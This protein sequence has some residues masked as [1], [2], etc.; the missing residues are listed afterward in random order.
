MR[1][2]KIKL[3]NY[4]QY[5]D[6]ELS[7]EQTSGNDLHIIV[8]KNGTGKTN[9][10]NAINWCL[11][12]EEP[13]LSKDSE[14]LP[15]LNT[16]TIAESDGGKQQVAVELW[17]QAD[18]RQRI[19]FVRKEYYYIQKDSPPTFS[20][21]DFYV[22]ITDDRGSTDISEDDD[23][24]VVA[25]RFVPKKIRD[26]FFFDGERL[27]NYFRYSTRE[28]IKSAIFGISQIDLLT[29]T[30]D[31]LSKVL[32]ELQKEAGRLS[33]E[34]DRIRQELEDK[35]ENL[36]EILKRIE[37]C[38]R[39]IE[40]AREK[41]AENR[42]KVKG[43]P[44]IETL[45]GIREKLRKKVKEI[46]EARENKQKE[47]ESLLFEFGKILMLY[48]TITKSLEI[49]QEK[50]KSGEILPTIDKDLIKRILEREEPCIC[51]RTVDDDAEKNLK[52]L[53]SK[54][55]VSSEV[56]RELSTMCIYLNEAKEKAKDFETSLKSIRRD[57]RQYDERLKELTDQISSIDKQIGGYD[58][59]KIKDW[60]KE[61]KK[62]EEIYEGNQQNL[63]VLKDQKEKIESRIISL[64][65]ERDK[66][67]G[68]VEKLEEQK[69]SID[70][71]QKALRVL[72]RSQKYVID[73]FKQ[74]MEEETKSLFF[75][76]I[77]K[78][79]TYKDII[80][81]EGYNIHLI[82]SIGY[83]SLGS[84]SASERELLALAFTIAL[85]KISGFA[86][87]IL[88]DTPATRLSSEHKEKFADIFSNLSEEKQIILL[89][90]PDEY[91]EEMRAILD[92]KVS[93][94]YELKLTPDEKEVRI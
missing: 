54:I 64:K 33:P 17:M 34:I 39:Q 89:V 71:T 13:H 11:Y 36:K 12:N 29:R 19:I 7:F 32:M 94:R 67:L 6:I 47:I 16:K 38:K 78:K 52:Q 21:S 81:D 20:S 92:K 8:G 42:D 76:L 10:L 25:D 44:D 26:F 45:E 75:N 74:E 1:I 4:R 91:S 77:W 3:K 53:L 23:A 93:N 15:R 66:E 85:H 87:S 59:E 72:E 2:E 27:D 30:E 68:K 22:E 14:Q 48:P 88:I 41:I 18:N 60:F 46:E 82:H 28:N 63:G 31:H 80:I 70:F 69:R 50:R 90:L 61:L 73:E 86:F 40:E 43:I 37:E 5:R 49:I 55:T 58:S 56:A 65:V 24:Q 9:L 57:I 35:E 84:A 51:G 62:F 83:D 79:G